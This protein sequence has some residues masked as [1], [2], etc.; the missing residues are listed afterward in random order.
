MALTKPILYTPSAFDATQPYTFIFNVVGGDQVVANRLTIKNQSTNIT[1]YQEKITTFNFS[2]TI[3]ANTLS[4]GGYY[5]AY[6]TTYNYSDTAS[7]Q[8]A[9]VQFHCYT[10]PTWSFSN[11]PTGGIINNS[12]YQFNVS[13]NQ[14]Q[15]ELLNN[16]SITLYDDEYSQVSTS[17]VKYVA[18]T[19]LPLIVQHTFSGFDNN[20]IYYIRA[21][22][23]TVNGME[24]DTGYVQLI[25]RYEIPEVFTSVTLNNNCDGGYV[26]IQSNFV[27]IEGKSQPSPPNYINGMVDATKSNNYVQWDKNFVI[28]DYSFCF[29]SKWNGF[30]TK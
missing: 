17:G 28:Y 20:E 4:N 24:I 18:S 16:Y 13:Y 9:T 21:I 5:S 27:N 19:N 8:S 26:T 11:I 7:T 25:I 6:I 3:P 1:V 2:H 15:G 29:C 30:K 14:T 23:T 12:A 22:G 10:E